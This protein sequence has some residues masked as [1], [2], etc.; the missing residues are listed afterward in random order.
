MVSATCDQFAGEDRAQT[1]PLCATLAERLSNLRAAT[2]APQS[3]FLRKRL[4]RDFLVPGLARRA[5]VDLQT[6]ATALFYAVV[7]FGVIRRL[8]AVD[9]EADAFAFGADHVIVPIVALQ[10]FVQF[11]EVRA[12]QYLPPPRL[13]VKRAP[14]VLPQVGL[15]TDHFVVVRNPFG[16]ELDSGVG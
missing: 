3:L 8:K 12:G 5:S 16:P 2:W 6:D 11:V 9:R 14:V 13:V 4:Y 15:V 1:R 10:K 7:G